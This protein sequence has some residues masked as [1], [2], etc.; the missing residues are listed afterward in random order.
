M[1]NRDWTLKLFV[2]VLGV[3]T[4]TAS[5]LAGGG[6][7]LPP[8]AH[9]KGYSLSA[10]AVATAAYNTDQSTAPPNVPFEILVGDT[11]VTPGTMFYLP[12]FFVDDSG[13]ALPG[14]PTDITDQGA[15]AE[16]LSMFALDAFGVDDF[17]VQVDDKITVLNDDYVRGVTTAP[18][19]DGTPAG[20]HYIICAAFL[21]PL[22]P[23]KHT[24]GI[25][26]TIDDEPVVFLSYDVTVR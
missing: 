16:F 18:L 26:G 9:A 4:F 7:V 1:C 14:F 22:T 5:A 23:G 13:G 20:T 6:N 25:R 17:I 11:T 15:D 8:S 3:F 19:P 24:V 21:T 10:I 12:I 2:A